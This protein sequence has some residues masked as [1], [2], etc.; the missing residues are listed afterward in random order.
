MEPITDFLCARPSIV[1]GVGRLFDFAGALNV[2]SYSSSPEQADAR[3]MREDFAMVGR[4]IAKAANELQ[5][6]QEK[7]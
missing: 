5:T 4:D 2:Y 7:R 6:S 1:E 3:A